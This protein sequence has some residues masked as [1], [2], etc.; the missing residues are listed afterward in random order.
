[1]APARHFRVV[2]GEDLHGRALAELITG[3]DLIGYRRDCSFDVFNDECPRLPPPTVDERARR[4]VPLPN[5]IRL[6]RSGSET[7]AP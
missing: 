6:H 1:M 3:F 4:S 2:A 7:D 5:R